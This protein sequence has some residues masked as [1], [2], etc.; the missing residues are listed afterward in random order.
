MAPSEANFLPQA[1][2]KVK[3]LAV[4]ADGVCVGINAS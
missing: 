3:D 4:M 2:L 1:R